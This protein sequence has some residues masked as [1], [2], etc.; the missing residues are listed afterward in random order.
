MRAVL[1]EWVDSCGSST[2]WQPLDADDDP[3]PLICRSLGWLLRDTPTCK[4]IVPHL[5]DDNSPTAEAQG[6]GEMAIP[7]QAIRR[8]QTIRLPAP[9]RRVKTRR[10]S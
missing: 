8:I 2:R 1:I 10:A 4:I 5:S 7:T 3:K 6:C 9:K